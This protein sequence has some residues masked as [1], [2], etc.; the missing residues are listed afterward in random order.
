MGAVVALRKEFTG[1]AGALSA[2]GR[3]L[4]RCSLSPHTV[5]AYKGTAGIREKPAKWPGSACSGFVVGEGSVE[6]GD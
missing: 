6:R 3:H 1:A 4:D 2:I 5:R